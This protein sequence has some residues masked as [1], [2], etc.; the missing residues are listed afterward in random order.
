MTAQDETITA[1]RFTEFEDTEP[2]PL[3]PHAEVP[4]FPVHC[5]PDKYARMVETVSNATQTDPAMAGTSALSALSACTGGHALILVRHGWREPLNLY[6][7][8]VAAPAERKSPVQQLMAAPLYAAERA[9]VA[10]SQAAR[11]EAE[12]TKEIAEREC[13]RRAQDAARIRTKDDATD[14]EKDNARLGALAARAI[15]DQIV[16]PEAPQL[17]ADDVTP[18]AVATLLADQG[19]RLA[20]ISAE[21]GIF[22]IIAGRYSKQ[23][24]MEVWL[25]GHPGDPIKVNRQSRDPQYIKRPALTL[26]L[27]IQP[28][29]LS[30]IA[31]NPPFRGRGLLARFLYARPISR[32][33]HRLIPAPAV[34]EETQADYA[35]EVAELATGLAGWS[36]DPA[37]MKLTPAARD[38][39]TEID[40]ALEPTLAGN[41]ELAALADWGGKFVGAVLR[42]AGNLHFGVHGAEGFRTPID[43][44]TMNN[45]AEI[46]GYFL[47][48]AVNTFAEMGT[49]QTTNDAVYLLERIRALGCD[50]VSERD[51]F[52]GC[53]RSRFPSMA[54]MIPALDRLVDHGYLAPQKQSKK[55]GGGRAPSPLYKVHPSVAFVANAAKGWS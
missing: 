44:T 49:D 34:D 32:V 3:T 22:D 42:I 41:G 30:A 9:L 48:C 47:A 15:L 54:A 6:T 21:G 10:N 11:T 28:A 43:V 20:I 25:K 31:A 18:E 46:G 52:S 19:G 39:V 17:I 8:T 4:P 53:N 40:A 2:I 1:E 23:P 26:A 14:D 55:V 16:V 5:L 50:E 13:T 33:G 29:V 37:I 24:N 7:V 27:M 35:T 45:A 36:G 12:M 51:M 38:A